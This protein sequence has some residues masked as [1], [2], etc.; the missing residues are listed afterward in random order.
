M[1]WYATPSFIGLP[2][3]AWGLTAGNRLYFIL[4]LTSIVAA[5][6]HYVYSRRKI[7]RNQWQPVRDELAQLVAALGTIDRP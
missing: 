5:S 1:W 2:L 7:A 4:L 6:V 3:A